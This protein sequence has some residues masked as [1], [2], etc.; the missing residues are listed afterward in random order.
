MRG[1]IQLA[2]VDTNTKRTAMTARRM[3]MSV[4]QKI[5][6]EFLVTSGVIVEIGSQGH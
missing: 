4:P 5:N 6:V 2:T 1:T 3:L